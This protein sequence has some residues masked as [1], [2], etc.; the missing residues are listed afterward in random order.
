MKMKQVLHKLEMVIITSL[1][2]SPGVSPLARESM[3]YK[4]NSISITILSDKPLTIGDPMDIALTLYHE[5]HEHPVLPADEEAF[6]PFILRDHTVKQ[7]RMQKGIYRTMAIYTLTVFQTGNIK[8]P[9]LEVQVGN[10]TLVT[11]SLVIPILSVLPKEEEGHQL[12]DIVP[13]YRARLKT[14]T[15][16][17]I[18][19]SII[20]SLALLL[21]L[22]RLILKK[23][24][25]E[26][27]AAQE[28]PV[29]D[30]YGYSLQELSNLKSAHR[31]QR[32]DPKT[33]YTGISHALRLYF[34]NLLN[35]R[36][37]EMT[38]AELRRYLKNASASLFQT[39]VFLSILKRSDLV[40][41]AKERPERKTVEKDIDGSIDMI[42]KAQKRVEEREEAERV[43]SED[44][45]EDSS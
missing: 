2:L 42:R 30:P 10:T 27:R 38:T 19:L 31:K 23:P 43:T 8:L 14:L 15:F 32:T 40:K 12:K 3:E 13:P 11:E 37:L 25:R 39:P 21:L 7:K 16:V 36:A 24:H 22:S 4:L 45:S 41:F 44:S 34:G 18:L 35:I 1:F 6:R 9:P 33:V 29:F 26:Q 5:R 17:I 20:A 28:E